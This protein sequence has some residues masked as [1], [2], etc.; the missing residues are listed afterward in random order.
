MSK[1]TSLRAT[2][3]AIMAQLRGRRAMQ[4]GLSPHSPDWWELHREI[5]ELEQIRHIWRGGYG[6]GKATC[7]EL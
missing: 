4:R 2:Y 7:L 3:G 1:A 6:R 5:G